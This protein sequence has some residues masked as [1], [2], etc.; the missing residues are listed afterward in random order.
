MKLK[1]PARPDRILAIA[2]GI[3]LVSGFLWSQRVRHRETSFAEAE[4]APAPVAFGKVEKVEIPVFAEA[5]GT[6]RS[7]R[8]TEIAARV[9]AEVRE[10]RHVPGDSVVGGQVLV[11]LDSRDLKARVE[12][13]RASLKAREEALAEARTEHERTKNLHAKQ[14]ATG[15]ELDIARY[16]LSGAQAQ[17]SAAAK[18]LEEAEVALGYATITAPFAGMIFEKRADPGDLAAPGKPLLGIY[19]PLQLR[20]EALIEERL[21]WTLK[22]KDSIDIFLDVLGRSVTGQVSEVVPAVDPT[23]RTGTVKIDLPEEPGIRPGMFGRARIPVARRE[24]IVVPRDAVV[25]RG[26]L[27]MVFTAEDGPPPW[28][29]RGPAGRYARMKLVRTG[30]AVPG[31]EGAGRI[32]ILSGLD[33]GSAGADVVVAGAA[34]LRDGSRIEAPPS[35]GEGRK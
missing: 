5:V 3:L 12:Q 25:R 11:V 17:E 27:A 31:P 8:Q 26:Q 7:R 10:V 16:R 1:L 15:Q 22:V 20:L 6:V 18:A 35:G 4:A 23:T 34:A 30:E 2:I 9:L 28:M 13:A 32:E 24:G 29:R 19:D 14:A 21:L 33:P